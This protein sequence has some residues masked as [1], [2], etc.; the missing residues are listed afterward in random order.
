MRFS[1]IALALSAL[2]TALTA[3]PVPKEKEKTKDEEVILGKWS[4]EKVDREGAKAPGAGV[5]NRTYVFEKDGKLTIDIGGQE[6][7]IEFK[8]DS[9]ASPKT[10]DLIMKADAK[11]TIVIPGIYELDGDSL[12]ICL[13][14]KSK[15][16]RPTEMKAVGPGVGVI[17]FQRAKEVKKDK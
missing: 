15:P 4:T 1:L 7:A 12:K 2:T 9:S 5:Q 10:I 8:L 17:T 13:C 6:A 3:A 16:V 14:E 11:N